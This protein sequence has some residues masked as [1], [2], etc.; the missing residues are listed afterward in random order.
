M[1]NKCLNWVRFA[2]KSF[3]ENVSSP[4]KSEGSGGVKIGFNWV[5]FFCGLLKKIVVTN[6]NIRGCNDI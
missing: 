3:C 6:C 5:R 1:L 4:E 2:K